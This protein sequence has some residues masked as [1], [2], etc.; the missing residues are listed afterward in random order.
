VVKRNVPSA[1][2]VDELIDLIKNY[3]DWVE[4]ES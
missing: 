4:P 1:S 2:A 3:G